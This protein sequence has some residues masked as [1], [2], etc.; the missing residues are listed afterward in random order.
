MDAAG[1]GTPAVNQE[2]SVLVIVPA[3]FIDPQNV[4]G[5][6][7]RTDENNAS[8]R[9]RSPLGRGGQVAVYL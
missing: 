9:S 4:G 3:A 5:K 8:N 6:N 7:T 2:W 1:A